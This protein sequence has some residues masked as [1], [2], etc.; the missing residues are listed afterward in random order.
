MINRPSGSG[1]MAAVATKVGTRKT[2]KGPAG[3]SW[4]E[5]PALIE[6]LKQEPQE[7]GRGATLVPRLFRKVVGDGD[8][9]IVLSQIYYWFCLGRNNKVRVGVY[10]DGRPWLAKQHK[11]LADELGMHE[12]TVRNCVEQLVKNGLVFKCFKF[13]DGKKTTHLHPNVDNLIEMMEEAL[14]QWP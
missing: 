6:W 11:E 3:D 14:K 2:S 8:Q 13:F 10:V 12:R 1:D 7:S 4:K 5:V 9:A